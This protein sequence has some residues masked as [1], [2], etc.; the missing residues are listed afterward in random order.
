MA[1]YTTYLFGKTF[2]RTLQ[3]HAE[4]AYCLLCHVTLVAQK[5]TPFYTCENDLKSQIR[6]L[7]TGRNRLGYNSCLRL[8]IDCKILLD[9]FLTGALPKFDQSNFFCIYM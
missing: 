1:I 8:Q 3:E 4:D 6:Q 2:A 9:G 7:H 5:K